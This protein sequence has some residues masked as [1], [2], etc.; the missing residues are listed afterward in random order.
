MIEFIINYK[1]DKPITVCRAD[2]FVQQLVG[3]YSKSVLPIINNLLVNR[4][5][6]FFCFIVVR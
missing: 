5:S 1:T 4:E 2:G 3:L 6:E